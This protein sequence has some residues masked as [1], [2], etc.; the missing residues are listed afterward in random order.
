[1]KRVEG[2]AEVRV[3]RARDH[4]KHEVAKAKALADEA[5]EALSKKKAELKSCQAKLQAAQ[6]EAEQSRS[7]LAKSTVGELRLALE[8]KELERKRTEDDL[9]DMAAQRDS[10]LQRLQ[11]ALDKACE[12]K[13]SL[14]RKEH[15]ALALERKDMERLRLAY[16]SKQESQGLRRDMGELLEIKRQVREHLQHSAG[17]ARTPVTLMPEHR[18][19]A[20]SVPD[21]ST[22]S[23]RFAA[24]P[25]NPIPQTGGAARPA[26]H[27]S[28]AAVQANAVPQPYHYFVHEKEIMHKV[29]SESE[30]RAAAASSGSRGRSASAS[31]GR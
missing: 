7:R 28:S 5:E 1:M 9:A 25:F 3:A 20:F 29:L 18:P 17:P 10:A 22:A 16:L 8:R 27:A 30:G 21:W 14:E 12:L 26:P 31:R 23:P 24:E 6:V 15:E 4:A 11:L 2:D 13:A 19:Q